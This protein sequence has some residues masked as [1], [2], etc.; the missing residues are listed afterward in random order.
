MH[1][2]KIT[3]QKGRWSDK[4]WTGSSHQE[5]GDATGNGANS[6]HHDSPYDGL[7]IEFEVRLRDQTLA[8]AVDL[9]K[10]PARSSWINRASFG[11]NDC[12]FNNQP[13]EPQTELTD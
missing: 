6:V 4:Y 13:P 10:D 11:R 3:K 1:C 2:Q 7:A 12:D 5:A 8:S 9:A